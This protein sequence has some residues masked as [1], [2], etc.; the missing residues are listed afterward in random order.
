MDT[1]EFGERLEHSFPQL[2]RDA[3]VDGL[4]TAYYNAAERWDES[5]GCDGLTFG[6]DVYSFACYD[7]KKR[8][9]R[10]AGAMD[11]KTFR[12]AF[13]LKIGEFE[14]AC[15]RVGRSEHDP[16]GS[17]F[18]QSGCTAGTL[19]YHQF[20]F[21]FAVDHKVD[22]GGVVIAHLGN[23]E[24]GLCAVYLC[25]A[26]HVDGSG[27]IDHWAYSELIWSRS[28]VDEISEEAEVAQSPVEEVQAPVVRRKETS[29]VAE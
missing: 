23:H 8:A 29:E 5:I 2:V 19:T 24:Q 11:V 1:L 4:H 14:A 6:V 25:A 13:R 12:P 22:Q 3:I 10:L 9:E 20:E 7:L 15:H 21:E 18:P 28:E 26:D 17:S 27:Q 16:I